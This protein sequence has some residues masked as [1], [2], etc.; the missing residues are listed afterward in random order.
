M[1]TLPGLEQYA[2][3]GDFPCDYV[4]SFLTKDEADE[5]YQ[6]FVNWHYCQTQNRQGARLRRRGVAFVPDA[7]LYNSQ[8]R[9]YSDG[10]QTLT[11]GSEVVDDHCDGPVLGSSTAPDCLRRLQQKLTAHLRTMPGY[12]KRTINY[13]SVQL[14]PD[15]DTGI[16]WHWH[17]EDYGI[18]TPTL[19]VAVGA[20]R[21]LFIGKANKSK[22]PQPAPATVSSKV[23][24]HGSLIVIPN[25]MNYTHWHA[26]LKDDAKN[27]KYGLSRGSYGPRVSVNTKCLVTARV[28]SE[29]G[30][31]DGTAYRKRRPRFAVYVG[32]QYA[33]MLDTP[34]GNH[35]RIMNEAGFRE[36]VQQKMSDPAFRQ[37]A[38]T[39]LR[40]R[41]LL[42]WCYQ[43]GPERA[44][45]CHARVWLE[46]VNRVETPPDGLQGTPGPESL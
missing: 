2:E 44:E 32:R 33:Y 10:S 42:C 16:D 35:R 31:W 19:L 7:Y 24:E 8:V 40:G 5:F 41:H 12:E 36:Y 9:G 28:F 18:D 37:K 26:I 6:F 25:E 11:D 22:P 14:Y 45:F 1:T 27:T 30:Q 3:G 4:P 21:Q 39:D 38:I 29:K 43:D 13:L 46:A 15:Q 20:E 17:T 23:F 34:Y